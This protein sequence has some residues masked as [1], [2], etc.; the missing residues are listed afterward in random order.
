MIPNKC[1][2]QLFIHLIDYNL[3]ARNLD[4]SH[5]PVKPL[6][7]IP[8]NSYPLMLNMRQSTRNIRYHSFCRRVLDE[9]G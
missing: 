7:V 3:K 2:T 9:M 8:D 5:G 6:K 4:D 1:A